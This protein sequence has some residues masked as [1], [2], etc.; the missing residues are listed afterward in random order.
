MSAPAESKAPERFPDDDLPI[1]DAHHH[2]WDLSL[3]KHPWLI[4][5]PVPGHRYGDYRAF[6]V[7]FWPEDYARAVGRHRIVGNVYMEAEWDHDDPI[8]ETRWIH[9]LAARTGFPHA[10][11]A[12]AWLDR[13]DVAEVLAAQAQFELVRAIRHKPRG[14]ARWQDWTPGHGLPGSML[15]PRYREGYARL[16]DHDLHFELQTP[17]WHLPDAADLAR[18]FPHI[19]MVINHAGVPGD[20]DPDTLRRWRAAMAE[21]AT[22]PNV[23]VK[24]SGLGVPGEAWTRES[25]DYV[26]RETIALFGAER[27]MFASNFP[28]DGLFRS[29]EGIFDDFKAITAGLAPADRLRLFHDNAKAVYRLT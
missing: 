2:Y 20:R 9:D 28:V 19:L 18:A 13:D 15:C 8:G 10:M 17:Y 6:C 29:L 14:V 4:D 1:I 26:V 16:A 3:R 5:A 12:Q 23:M 24:I 7:D 27:C 25:N 21:V 22:C 11:I